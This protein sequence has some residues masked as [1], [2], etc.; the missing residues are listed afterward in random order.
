MAT[1]R[2]PAQRPYI[3]LRAKV[4]RVCKTDNVDEIVH[5]AEEVTTFFD[6]H[7]W[8]DNWASWRN[9]FTDALARIR[10]E[11]K[12]SDAAWMILNKENQ[13]QHLFRS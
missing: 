6:D 12:D 10:W 1:R 7:G 2:D 9:S 3:P 11:Q 8:P 13:V 4:T 5:T